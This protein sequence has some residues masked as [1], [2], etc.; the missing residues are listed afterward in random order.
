VFVMGTQRGL[1][2]INTLN[3][4]DAVVVDAQGQLHASAGLLNASAP[5]P[6]REVAA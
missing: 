3:D 2:L 4:V 5:A 1:A 6:R